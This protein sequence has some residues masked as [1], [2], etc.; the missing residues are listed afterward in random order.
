MLARPED[1]LCSLGLHIYIAVCLVILWYVKENSEMVPVSLAPGI[2]TLANPFPS[3][4][5]S[6]N[7]D[8]IV[9]LKIIWQR[10]R[11]LADV[12]KVPHQF[13]KREI[14]QDGPDL[15]R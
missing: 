3:V 15:I 11:D 13:V 8:W 6:C 5:G 2:H 7:Y 12:I 4:G 14:F 1:G 10:G 9:I